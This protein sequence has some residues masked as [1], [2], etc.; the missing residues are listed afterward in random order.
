METINITSPW[1]DKK[2]IAAHFRVCPR[3]VTDWQKRK[4]IPYV[5][6]G[7]VVRFH[8]PRCERAIEKMEIKSVC[9]TD[10]LSRL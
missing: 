3:L 9:E 4:R 5:K 2:G 10:L 8:V 6:I 7:R 1:R